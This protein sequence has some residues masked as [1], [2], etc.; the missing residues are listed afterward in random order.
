LESCAHSKSGVC[1]LPTCVENPV[2]VIAKKARAI[3]SH[4]RICVSSRDWCRYG[5]LFETPNY[6]SILALSSCVVEEKTVQPVLAKFY[7]SLSDEEK[8]RFNSLR[9]ASRPTGRS[10]DRGMA[11]ADYQVAAFYQCPIWQCRGA[12]LV[13]TSPMS[14][15][16]T[17]IV[18]DNDETQ[19]DRMSEEEL[20]RSIA[21]RAN[22]PG[23]KIG[24]SIGG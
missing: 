16:E 8:A 2:S 11:L 1:A 5:S 9:S 22:K 12:D 14:W 7:N 20:I 6:P 23:V 13:D 19:F 17:R 21:D 4:T 10:P 3:S 24:M 15:S 18:K